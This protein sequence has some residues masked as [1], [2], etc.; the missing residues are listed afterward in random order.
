M[1]KQNFIKTLFILLTF[2]L[3]LFSST[4]SNSFSA[5]ASSESSAYCWQIIFEATQKKS[6]SL[7]NHH[8]YTGGTPELPGVSAKDLKKGEMLRTGDGVTAVVNV[9]K[10]QKAQTVYN[11]EV[12][13]DHVYRIGQQALLIKRHQPV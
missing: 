9:I 2:T 3:P 11:I 12:D 10:S 1:K 7:K 8:K 6:T 13:F 4:L 5:Y